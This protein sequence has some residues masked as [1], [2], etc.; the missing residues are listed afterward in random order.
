MPMDNQPG[1]SPVDPVLLAEKM[2][3]LEARLA[4][5]EDRLR[6]GEPAGAAETPVSPVSRGIDEETEFKL[7]QEW[8]SRVGIAALGIGIAFTLSLP[9]RDLPPAFPSVLGY[10][11]AAGFFIVAGFCR[12]P[13]EPISGHLRATAMALF[14]F[15]S[16]RLCFF[17]DRRVL[18]AD[19]IAGGLV[20]TLAAG[21][22]LAIALRRKSPWLCGL[23]LFTGYATALAVGS[24]G[25]ALSL[26]ALFSFAAVA[27]SRL[28]SRPAPILIAMPLGYAT[29]VAWALNN[30]FLG[31]PLQP[32]AYPPWAPGV[33][34]VCLVAF[35]AGLRRSVRGDRED[36]LGNIGFLLNGL[37]G[38]G[39]FLLHTLAAS[40]TWFAGDQL[41]A[42]STLLGLAIFLAHDRGGVGSFV[43]AMTGF[44]ALSF[45]IIK[46]VE[47]PD[48]FVWLSLQSVIVVATAIWLCSRLMIVANFLIY[49]CILGAYVAVARREHGISLGFGLVALVTARLLGWKKDRLE[50]KTELMRNAY[51]VAVFFI[52]PYG[53]Y[54]LVPG[55][56]VGLA[57]VGASL[58]YYL[59][60]TILANRKYRW[61]GHATLLLTVL[62]LA[63]AGI[64]RLEPLFRNLSILVLGTVLVIASLIF[65]RLRAKR[66]TASGFQN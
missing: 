66:K 39:I 1:E 53:L 16:L 56:W 2:R 13:F 31:R 30:P 37:A 27:A 4:L 46:V 12:R 51:L 26:M 25:L 15:A 10:V 7:G 20:L 63:V 60:G 36:A 18:S 29:Y 55:A 5:V 28:L 44:L 21:A 14:Y 65:A 50:L 52:F 48:V 59:L 6:M 58:L 62:Y 40:D 8:F 17:G 54:H 9:F 45:A 23:A 49:L 34:L 41:V 61:M 57:W 24:P 33:L 32:V 11:L 42:F 43:Y 35:A 3:R 38:Y 22:N 19:S 64:S 47:P